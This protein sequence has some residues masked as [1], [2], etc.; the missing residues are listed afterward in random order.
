MNSGR[1]TPKDSTDSP[2]ARGQRLRH[3]IHEARA[4]AGIDSDNQLALRANVHYDTLM[5][6]YRGATVPRPSSVR[7]IADVLGVSYGD[8]LAAYDGREPAAVPLE[9]AVADLI[10]EIRVAVV[11]ER[12][13]RTAMMRMIAASLA[14][15]LGPDVRGVAAASDGGQPVDKSSVPSTLSR[16]G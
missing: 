1:T 2:R 16:D 7:Q 13:A 9:Q 12:Q 14:A 15:A 11:G 4:A 10:V 6:W 8:L 5:N 3:A